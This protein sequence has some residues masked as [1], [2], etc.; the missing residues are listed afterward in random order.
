MTAPAQ[1]QSEPS[2]QTLGLVL[3]IA[4][5]ALFATKGIIVKLALAEGI[6]AV[7][8]L[9][10]RMLVS[11]PIFAGVGLWSWRQRARATGR[12]GTAL[13]DRATLAKAGG[14]GVLG[15][16]LASYFDFA[17]LEYI[18][19]Q[20]D[21]LIL[22]TYPFFVVLFGVVL[23]RRK[24]TLPMVLALVL[25]YCGIMLIFLHDFRVAGDTVLLGSALALGSAIAYAGYQILAKPLIDRMGAQLFTSV[26]MSAA[27]VLVFAHFLLTH[28]ISALAVT[29]YELSL[30]VGIGL[31]STVLPAYCISWAIGLVGSERTAVV[32]NISPVATVGLAVLV[33]GEAFTPFHLAGTGLVLIG[34]W[35]FARRPRA[36]N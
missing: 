22:L 3:A 18:S 17:A 2:R 35:L 33:L 13:P 32:G 19:A 23:F 9:A 25:S 14:V 16:Y 36:K 6:D 31:F 30:M 1:P 24:V 28:P 12:G 11:V 15:Y 21:R 5:A 29:G 26:A 8:T 20:L 4:G 7:T 27:G 34:V 10:W